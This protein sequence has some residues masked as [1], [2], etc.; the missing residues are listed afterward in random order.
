MR[1]RGRVSRRVIQPLHSAG[2]FGPPFASVP[3][4]ESRGRAYI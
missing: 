2:A 4:A 3:V 1:H